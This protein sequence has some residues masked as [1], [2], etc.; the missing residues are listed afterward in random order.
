MPPI[1]ATLSSL[2][3][4][5]LVLCAAAKDATSFRIPNWISLALVALF[6]AA[7]FAAG[8][9]LST[10]ALNAGIGAAVLAVGMVMFALRWMGGGDT[11]LF[12]AVA[13]W[14]GWPALVNFGL[15]AALTGGV[16]ALAL[17]YLRSPAMRP[18]V[19]TGPTWMTRL[20]E[21]GEGVPYG[22]AIAAGALA[23]FPQTLFIKGLGL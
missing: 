10:M 21:P 2:A 8:M 6:P 11:K 22:V 14:L 4:A 1:L 15:A 9:P 16:L 23:A 5:G 7:A 3:F 20:A 13:L 12:A 17:L 18:F 19:L